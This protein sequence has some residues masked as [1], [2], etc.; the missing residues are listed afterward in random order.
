MGGCPDFVNR[1]PP[2]NI[3]YGLVF[4]D[5][6]P[7]PLIKHWRTY[8]PLGPA[9]TCIVV[10]NYIRKATIYHAMPRG[11]TFALLFLFLFLGKYCKILLCNFVEFD[12]M[13][14]HKLH[15]NLA[16]QPCAAAF[17]VRIARQPCPAALPDCL[18]RQPCPAALPGSLAR[19][20]CPAPLTGSL[21]RQ[22]CPAFTN[23]RVGRQSFV[24]IT[25]LQSWFLTS[26]YTIFSF[27]GTP[28]V[29]FV[30]AG[31]DWS[32]FH[33]C[34]KARLH[35]KWIQSFSTKLGRRKV[36]ILK[37]INGFLF[38]VSWDTYLD[39]F[40]RHWKNT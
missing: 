7:D 19:Q 11:S 38:E 39:S 15:D 31:K 5:L 27:G 8:K 32:D 10:G 35:L 33:S 22:P 20:P 36:A 16:R 3:V 29:Q 23:R 30:Y 9:G 21:A 28:C 1:P 6:A 26:P 37:T 2:M 17:P 40:G 24:K 34:F 18:A 13:R 25:S 14:L 4:A 12:V